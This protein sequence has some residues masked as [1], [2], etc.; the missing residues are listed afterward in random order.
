MKYENTG[1]YHIIAQYKTRLYLGPIKRHLCS[2]PLPDYYLNVPNKLLD[3]TWIKGL[4]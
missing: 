2:E 1:S 4:V 3:G